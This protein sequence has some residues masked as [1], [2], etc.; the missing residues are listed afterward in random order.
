MLLIHN[1]ID[2]G[3]QRSF[4]FLSYR[5]GR[6]LQI[7]RKRGEGRRFFLAAK[8]RIE[9]TKV[10][11][12]YRMDGHSFWKIEDHWLRRVVAQIANEEYGKAAHQ[13]TGRRQTH[14]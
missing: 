2:Y 3:S 14:D 4:D 8:K 13:D 9:A 5:D 10:G 7:D 12:E 1:T 6:T 11:N